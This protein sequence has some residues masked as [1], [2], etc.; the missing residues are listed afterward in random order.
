MGNK[1]LTNRPVI[2][3]DMDDTIENLAEAWVKWLNE[4]Y[5][6]S[7]SK[8]DLT[9]WNVEQFFPGLTRQQ[10]YEP[11]QI[12]DFWKTVEPKL[13]AMEYLNRTVSDGYDV[14]LCTSTHYANVRAKYEY[15]VKRYFPYIDWKH[16]IITYRKQLLMADYLIDDGPHNLIGGRYKKILMTAPHNLDFNAEANDMVRVGNWAEIYEL[17]KADK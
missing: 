17:I 9:N 16:V 2:L 3:V 4:K 8:N 11:M 10:V 6:T 13:D 5:G 12:D 14:Y 7:V 1:G 15:I